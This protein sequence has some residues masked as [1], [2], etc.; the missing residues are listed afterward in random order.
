MRCNNED[1]G[2]ELSPEDEASGYFHCSEECLHSD[3]DLPTNFR[4]NPYDSLFDDPYAISE[5]EDEC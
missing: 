3:V 2:A 1:C 5:D 4:R